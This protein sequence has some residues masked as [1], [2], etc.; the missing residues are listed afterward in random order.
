MPVKSPR[1]TRFRILYLNCIANLNRDSSQH[2]IQEMYVARNIE[3][4]L[5]KLSCRGKA[6]SVTYYE[7]VFV[8][9]VTQHAKFKC[10]IIL[11]SVARTALPYLSTL[12]HKRHVFEGKKNY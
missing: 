3:V 6:I 7:G 8:A 1:K 9:L 4:L 12:S 11:L 10:H 5:R 2:D